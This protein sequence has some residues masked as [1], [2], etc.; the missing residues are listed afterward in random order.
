VDELIK[1]VTEKAGISP[2]QAKNAVNSVLEFIK[3][4]APGI[5]DQITALISGGGGGAGNVID[6][7]RGKLGI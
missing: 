6:S 7:V 1:K 2:E 3:T 4:K 5:G